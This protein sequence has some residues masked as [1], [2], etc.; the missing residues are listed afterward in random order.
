LL[1]G[2]PSGA[3]APPSRGSVL[4]QLVIDSRFLA[5]NPYSSRVR[6]NGPEGTLPFFEK[7][8]W[9][10]CGRGSNVGY[11]DRNARAPEY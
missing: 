1:A 2:S 10:V 7:K 11:D 5:V 6:S 3:P 4:G 9:I 8:L